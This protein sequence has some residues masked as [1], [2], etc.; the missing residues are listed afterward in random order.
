[1]SLD[2]ARKNS[3]ANLCYT[4]RQ[5]QREDF[6]SFDDLLRR[7]AMELEDVEPSSSRLASPN[8]PNL[9]KR[10]PVDVRTVSIRHPKAPLIAGSPISFSSA[11][12]SSDDGEAHEESNESDSDSDSSDSDSDV[13]SM[14]LDGD[15]SPKEVHSESI[16]DVPIYELDEQFIPQSPQSLYGRES[17]PVFASD[18]SIASAPQSSSNPIRFISPFQSP[19]LPHRAFTPPEEFDGAVDPKASVTLLSPPSIISPQRLAKRKRI[20]TSVK[21]KSKPCFGSESDDDEAYED[22]E[23]EDDDEY[24]PS[25]LL[26]PKSYKR[27]RAAAAP[28]RAARQHKR[29]NR[30][31]SVSHPR[32]EASHPTAKRRRIAPESRNLQS[33]APVLL[34]A[35]G[36]TSIEDC[37]FVCPACGWEQS[38]KRMPDY[39]RHLKTHL[40]PDKQDK[41]RGWWCK[42]VRIEDKDGFNARCKENGLKRIEDDAE[43]YWFHD[44]MRVGG[45]CQ[46]F[47]RRDALK[48]HV[49]NHN[50]RCGGVIAEGLKEGDY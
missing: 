42:G 12:S 23:S 36:N 28:R 16:I 46:T 15:Y 22:D 19:G 30:P 11:S 5:N 7:H 29:I 21:R 43:P 47:S 27:G 6:D 38:N 13:D 9:T 34:E 4:I 49:A 45:C 32:R 48:R 37:D 50:V 17:L 2:A 44:H 26:A 24:S 33:D 35:I 41:T 3:M 10:P 1:M 8:S 39:Q 31:S 18:Y 25:P 40:R 20:P 14:A